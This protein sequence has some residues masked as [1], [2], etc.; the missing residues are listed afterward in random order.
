KGSTQ[1]FLTGTTIVDVVSTGRVARVASGNNLLIN[2]EA[3][4]N[5]GSNLLANKSV[6]LS[7]TRLNNRSYFGY[8]QDEYNVYSYYGK[9]A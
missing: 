6:N 8:A 4:D 3:L 1:K 2:A 7:G 5:L 9:L